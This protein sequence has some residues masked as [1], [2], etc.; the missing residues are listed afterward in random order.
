MQRVCVQA[1]IPRLPVVHILARFIPDDSRIGPDRRRVAVVEAAGEQ[2]PF[3]AIGMADHADALSIDLW[4]RCQRVVAIR[5]DIA[6]KR[7]RLNMDAGGVGLTRVAAGRADGESYKPAA[8]Q[9]QR[10]IA[11]APRAQ[12]DAGFRLVIGNED[13]RERAGPGRD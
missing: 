11:I 5:A 1:E 2:G 8:G 6:E 12:A 4:Q 13:R 3:A 9:L 10:E 7:K